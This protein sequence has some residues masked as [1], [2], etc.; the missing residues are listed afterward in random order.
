MNVSSDD[1]SPYDLIIDL[2]LSPS[3]NSPPCSATGVAAESCRVRHRRTRRDSEA[4]VSDTL[5][6]S[7]RELCFLRYRLT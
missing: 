3:T 2:Q 7:E 1:N 5:A 4:G 6:G